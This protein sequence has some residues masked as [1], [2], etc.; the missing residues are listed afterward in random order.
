QLNTKHQKW[1]TR[2]KIM[3]GMDLALDES[4]KNLNQQ[5]KQ[6]FIVTHL[7]DDKG[8]AAQVQKEVKTAFNRYF[9]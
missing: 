3:T 9:N 8:K 1:K 6:I 7:M 5:V 4:S 2:L